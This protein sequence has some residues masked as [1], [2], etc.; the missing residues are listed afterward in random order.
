MVNIKCYICKRKMAKD[1]SGH[2]LFMKGHAICP[3]CEAS[4]YGAKLINKEEQNI[5]S[6]AAQTITKIANKEKKP[7]KVEEKKEE[8]KE[9]DF[10]F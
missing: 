3:E 1:F 8:K 5:N 9:N 2:L 6:N 10:F 7:E 4:Q